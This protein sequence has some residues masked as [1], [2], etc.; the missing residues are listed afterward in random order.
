VNSTTVI[1][2]RRRPGSP[3][4]QRPNHQEARSERSRAQI[5]RAALKLFSTRG[6]HGTSVRDIADAAR[7]STGNVYHQFADKESLFTTLLE[8]Y[9]E[10]L[11]QPDLP[12]NKALAEGGF[13]DDLERLA[14]GA[15]ASVDQYRRYVALIYVDVVEFE[16]THIRRFY[17]DM[18]NRFQAFLEA[19]RGHLA[20]DRLREGVPPLTAIMMASRFFIQYYGVEL[21]FGVPNHFGVDDEEALKQI[22][23]I[24]KF[25]MFKQRSS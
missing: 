2:R 15:R 8:Q 17:A 25:G 13:P 20:L 19:N 12:F 21:L 5:L 18:A 14:R 4:R 24:L 6:Y 11:A 9:W 1:E 7:V 23:D 10:A 16:G 3:A 22:I